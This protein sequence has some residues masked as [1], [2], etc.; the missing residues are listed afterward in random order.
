VSVVEPWAI[1]ARNRPPRL[2]DAAKA[3][4]SAQESKVPALAPVIPSAIKIVQNHGG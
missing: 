3:L 1:P 4:R 2:G